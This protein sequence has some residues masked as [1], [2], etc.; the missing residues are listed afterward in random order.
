MKLIIAS[1]L[2]GSAY[3]AKKL[4]EIALSEQP[5]KIILLGDIYYHGPRNPF[6]KEYAPMAVA[7]TLNAVKD[8]LVVIK[9]NCDSEVDQMISEFTFV[10]GYFVMAMRTRNLI[11]V[12]GH[13]MKS[14]D[15]PPLSKGDIVAY[16]HFHTG[17]IEQRDGII[18]LNPGS[19]AL[20]KDEHSYAVLDDESIT[21]KSVDA[22]TLITLKL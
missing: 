9:G 12:H 5:D 4:M 20:P 22:R 8:K 6:P 19:I 3:Y 21:V 7:E 1:D 13:K 17:V 18:Y 14:E 10:E 2:H 16:G 11:C 15:L